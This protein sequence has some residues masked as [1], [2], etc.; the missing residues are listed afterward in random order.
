MKP[1]LP[2]ATIALL[3]CLLAAC[4]QPFQPVGPVSN[5]LVLYSI[6]N[7]QSLSTT[8]GTPPA[9]DVRDALVQMAGGGRVI[10][11]RDT[12]V[13]WLDTQGNIS[14]TNVYVAYNV[15]VTPGAQYQLSASTPSGLSASATTTAL[16]LPTFD[17]YTGTPGKF[18][19]YTKFN[20]ISG[21]YVVHFYLEYYALIDNGWELRSEE[22][23]VSFFLTKAGDTVYVY[24]SF[25]RVEALPTSRPEVY[26]QFDSLLWQ[27]AEVGIYSRYNGEVVF[28][29]LEFDF[30]QIDDILYGYYYINNAPADRSTI[31]L[32]QPVY[33][34]IKNGYGIFGSRVE[35]IR[36]FPLPR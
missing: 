28:M 17:L 15:N 11:F 13:Q 21:V 31:R 12:T 1:S 3:A 5:N 35:V 7:S 18:N 6:L 14:P 23:P 36:Q 29:Q 34:N 27:K 24:P 16:A 10:R 20:S 22:M 4:N 25:S 19:F 26:V 9:P 33:T 32:D 8:Y 30:T 2:A